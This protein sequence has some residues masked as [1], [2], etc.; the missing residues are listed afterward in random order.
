[1][2]GTALATP[3]NVVLS[4]P[5]TQTFCCPRCEGL[6]DMVLGLARSVIEESGLELERRL[7]Q[8]AAGES[9][10]PFIAELTKTERK[11]FAA[12]WA[13]RGSFAPYDTLH[14]AIYGLG[15]GMPADAHRIRVIVTRLRAKIGPL[16]YRIT[17]TTGY[18]LRLDGP[19]GEVAP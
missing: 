11:L 1:M 16:G 15:I 6:P 8:W 7:A 10:A 13:M 17:T 2:N 14:R 12:L 19:S 9:G 3:R 4:A 18:G 5:L